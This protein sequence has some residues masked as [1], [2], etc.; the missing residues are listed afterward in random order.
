M[1]HR[2]RVHFAKTLRKPQSTSL[3]DKV[4]RLMIDCCFVDLSPSLRCTHL[5]NLPA[6]VTSREL[7]SIY[8]VHV[9]DILLKPANPLQSHLKSPGQSLSAEAWIKGTLHSSK[10]LRGV[11]ISS[12]IV[13]EPRQSAQFCRKFQQGQC[14]RLSGECFYQHTICSQP[15]SCTSTDCVHGHS[16]SA[17]RRYLLCSKGL[18]RLKLTGLSPTITREELRRSLPRID[19]SS[20]IFSPE[21]SETNVVYVVDQPS[22]NFLRKLIQQSLTLECQLETNED[23]FEWEHLAGARRSMV[24]APKRAGVSFRPAPWHQRPA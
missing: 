21:R 7:A 16:F 15:D 13:T 10:Q 19:N 1:I 9:A 20:L 17:S 24:S 3:E 4:I 22:G 8:R 23:F 2:F 18:Y 5:T 12:E 6:D 14:D 11:Q